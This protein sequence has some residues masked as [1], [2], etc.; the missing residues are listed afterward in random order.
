M[1]VEGD[2]ST[3]DGADRYIKGVFESVQALVKDNHSHSLDEELIFKYSKCLAMEISNSHQFF[4]SASKHIFQ[5][6]WASLP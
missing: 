5:T 3:D 1:E 2:V 4:R 6:L